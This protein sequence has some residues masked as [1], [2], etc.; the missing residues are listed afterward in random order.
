MFF[1]SMRAALLSLPIL[2]CASAAA[3]SAETAWDR[4]TGAEPASV[5]AACTEIINAGGEDGSVAN[6]L[7]NRAIAHVKEKRLPQAIED[8]ER[9]IKL[10]S[11]DPDF[12]NQI[13][14]VQAELGDLKKA[15][16]SLTKAIEIAPTEQFYLERGI[17]YYKSSN[18]QS[19]ISDY[20][21]SIEL[22]R[23]ESDVFYNRG[24]V[25][26]DQ[27]E[28][29]KALAD[30]KRAAEIAPDDSDTQYNIADMH[31][32]LEEYPAAKAEFDRLIEIDPDRLDVHS[33]R[34]F[35]ELQLGN[36]E[37]AIADFDT[38]IARNP[39]DLDALNNRGEARLL[40]GQTDAA[41]ADLDRALAINPKVGDAYFN[42]AIAKESRAQLG[43]A[44]SDF[45]LALANG[46]LPQGRDEIATRKITEIGKRLAVGKGADAVALPNSLNPLPSQSPGKLARKVAL[47]IGNGNYQFIP[48]LDNPANDAT[49][50][51]ASLTSLGFEVSVS[52]DATRSEMEESLARF[53]K[54]SQS[55]DTALVFYAGHGIQNDGV[56][57]LIPVDG[58]LQDFTDIRRF[59][60][61]KDVIADLQQARNA[62]ILI[63]DACRDNAA[64]VELAASLP[65]TRSASIAKGLAEEKA[66]GV[67]VAF[68]TQPRQ[69]AE[70]TAGG[71][72]SPFTQALLNHLGTPGLDIR[73]VMTRVRADV[74]RLT[75]GRQRPEVSDSLIGEFAFK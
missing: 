2:L 75:D 69:V 32:S 30:F 1:V 54:L 66:E 13:G 22:G 27:G 18:Y 70:D 53:S 41:I 43:A 6:A 8:F 21:Q 52:I 28:F 24:L 19:A 42:R 39:D 23:K 51:A 34:G 10:K 17:F 45:G 50:M 31:L 16:L 46:P 44:L 73:L 5:V 15:I 12:Y 55:A 35:A 38:E 58:G 7:Y 29:A 40:I 3:F 9:A 25:F 68:S 60:A 62:R 47:V 11:D 26:K 49:A 4:C 14:N 74:V 36:T 37:A 56:N 72:N 63:L 71:T 61:L 48:K 64:L 33:L 65:K 57:Y 20:T 67:L 59:I